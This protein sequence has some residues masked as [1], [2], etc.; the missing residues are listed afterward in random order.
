MRSWATI[1]FSSR[2]PLQGA[3]SVRYEAGS[4]GRYVRAAI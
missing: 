3:C 2:T 1:S 4:T